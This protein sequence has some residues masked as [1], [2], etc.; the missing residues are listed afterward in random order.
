M[1]G[2][3]LFSSDAAHAQGATSA[4]ASA[5]APASAASAGAPAASAAASASGSAPAASAGAKDSELSAV[6]R[7][8][9]N[10]RAELAKL[11]PKGD[12]AAEGDIATR[13][14]KYGVSVGV[15]TAIYFPGFAGDTLD[16][17]AGGAMPY[18]GLFP[19]FWLD[20]PGQNAYC[21]LQWSASAA[22]AQQAAKAAEGTSEEPSGSGNGA[23]APAPATPA[24]GAPAPA[25]APPAGGAPAP[26]GAAPADGSSKETDPD[27]AMTEAQVALDSAED[28]AIVASALTDPTERGAA[29][30]RATEKVTEAEQ[31]VGDAKTAIAKRGDKRDY[32]FVKEQLAHVKDRREAVIDV[33]QDALDAS[34]LEFDAEAV[35]AVADEALATGGRCSEAVKA[36]PLVN[37]NKNAARIAELACSV[38]STD[39]QG[40]ALEKR[41]DV[42][43]REYTEDSTDCVA[44]KFGVYVGYP[45]MFSATTEI[46]ART[47]TNRLT[48]DIT[49]IMSAGLVISPNALFALTFGPWVGNASLNDD[50]DA[51]I[52]GFTSGLAVTTDVFSAL[53]D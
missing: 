33:L 15:S 7:K 43:R 16:G 25:P 9:A 5:S 21:A 37:T 20:R 36:D 46:D 34:E 53:A 44:H 26:G 39:A 6:L 50:D 47:S 45:G 40:L 29:V 31:K 28:A 35:V 49:P 52:W 19:A 17:V 12:K 51:A 27:V 14:I 1:A 11:K 13:F 38:A 10:T 48:R 2:V 30:K 32:K 3:A 42:I 18:I 24:S 8:V 23:P 41:K 22:K 4:S